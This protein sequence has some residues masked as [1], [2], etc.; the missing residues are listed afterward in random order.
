MKKGQIIPGLIIAGIFLF[1]FALILI[2]IK[3]RTEQPTVIEPTTY[4]T[5]TETR[6]LLQTRTQT[7]NC[8][9]GIYPDTECTPGAVFPNLTKK[10]I[11]WSGYSASVRDVPESLKNKIY[12]S[13]N[14]IKVPYE[15]ECD[16]LV[17]LSIGGNNDIS[18]LWIQKYNMTLGAYDKDKIE[19]CFHRMVCDGTLDL[20]EA[21]MIMAKNWT[22]GIEICGE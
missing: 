12:K 6:I 4:N 19:N 17:P 16:H 21:Q 7:Q 15:N 9:Q 2:L 8:T 22:I 18:N 1:L 13:Y 5:T 11:C 3:N 10:D 20:R 14:V